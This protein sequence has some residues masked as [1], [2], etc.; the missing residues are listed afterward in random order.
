M[1]EDL[2]LPDRTA[3]AERL[4]ETW[5]AYPRAACVDEIFKQRAVEN[6][7]SVA[8]V[9]KGEEITY[10]QLDEASDRV[11]RYILAE[12]SDCGGVIA[13]C[14]GRSSEML[15]AILAILKA[16]AAYLPLDLDYPL[17]RVRYMIDD[18]DCRLILGTHDQLA[19]LQSCGRAVLDLDTHRDAIDA[20]AMTA[21]SFPRSASDV[22]YVMFTSGTTGKPKGIA[23]MHYNI[24]RLVLNTNYVS[25]SEKDV[26]LQLASIAFDA[27]TFEIWG[28]LLNGA[29]LV[30]YDRPKVDIHRLESII[31]E[32]QVSILWLSAGLFNQVADASA[33]VFAPVKQLLVGGDVL[34]V[35]HVKQVAEANPGCQIINGYGPT[36]CTTF[37]VCFRITPET[38]NGTSIPIGRPISNSQAYILDERLRPVPPGQPGELFIGGDGLSRGYLRSPKL[39]AD[40]FLQVTLEGASRRVYRTGDLVRLGEDGNI[41]FLGRADRQ[42]KIRG[43]RVE[44]AE[45]EAAVLACPG[46]RQ[47]AVVGDA[48]KR[49]DKRLVA[50]VVGTSGA[51]PGSLELRAML[52]KSLPSYMLPATFVYLDRIPLTTNGKVDRALLP[53]PNWKPLAASRA[54]CARTPMEKAVEEICS[55]V[56]G[57]AGEIRLDESLGAAGARLEEIVDRVSGWY[58]VKLDADDFDRDSISIAT[59]VNRVRKELHGL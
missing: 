42:L 5:T 53:K 35:N 57:I 55:S 58:G 26:F 11:A 12:A 8:L 41:H 13:V 30:L 49:G 19:L 22:A 48:G 23:V 36:E 16:G 7:E 52:Q 33:A 37:S 45:V 51:I 9:Y 31:R 43:F 59:L 40:K 6:P 17:D 20:A 56:L 32:N 44:P 27:S 29:K 28:A 39:N 14:I 47:A 34:S 46:I 2:V 3:L 15:V 18:A 21:P 24:S 38:R 54:D 25:I 4:N 50:Y 1:T 10:R